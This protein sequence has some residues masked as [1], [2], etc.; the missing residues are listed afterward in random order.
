MN[1]ILS[2]ISFKFPLNNLSNEVL[3]K[4]FGVDEA[5]ILRS[6]GIKNRYIAADNEL[7]SDLA[8]EAAESFFKNS[9]IKK[10]DIDFL[11]FC[12]ECYDF[13]AP[14]S[15]CILQSKLG[16]RNN[17]GVID[18][19]YGCSGYVYGLSIAKSLI[20]SKVALNVLFITAD[21]STK[22]LPKNNLELRSIFSDAASVTYITSENVNTIGNFVFGT[23]G[24]G[25]ENIYISRSG[26][27]DPIN[28]DFINNERLSNG[29][30][31]MKGTEIFN[32]GLRVVPQLVKDTLLKNNLEFK[33]IDLFIFHQPTKFLL[34]TLK[35]K[36]G[37]PDDKFFINIENHG[38]TVSCTI[39]LALKDAEKN[40]KIIPGMTI[41]LA[42]FGI[43]YSWAG[44]IIKT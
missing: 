42:G 36:M 21:T 30:M 33:D 20:I 37:I 40:G 39:P 29:K 27:K 32:F 3:S 6:T 1:S 28:S 23:D 24:S 5:K 12:S 31:I 26:F 25:W 41:L 43:G 19:P 22:T 38:N 11:I 9:G 2:N 17:I 10:Q 34:E 16:L 4:E 35:R 13:I 14:N 44:T 15:S 7:A 18:L 8:Y